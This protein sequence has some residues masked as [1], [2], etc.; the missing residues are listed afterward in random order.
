MEE[1]VSRDSFG[2][3]LARLTENVMGVTRLTNDAFDM[4]LR[5]M[6]VA[7]RRDVSRLAMQLAR[8]EDKLEMVLQEVE[9]LRDDLAA[10][11][12]KTNGRPAKRSSTP[13]G[14]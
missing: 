14:S 8:T 12:A 3:I 9:R 1:L 2:E 6:R 10:E 11:R 4:A 7:G 5:N 13:S